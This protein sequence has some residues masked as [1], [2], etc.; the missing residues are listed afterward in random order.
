M[1]RNIV[2]RPIF[3]ILSLI[4]I[5][6]RFLVRSLSLS[7][8]FFFFPFSPFLLFSFF[9]SSFHLFISNPKI[10]SGAE[11][12]VEDRKNSKVLG[13]V[14]LDYQTI[15]SASASN[16]S[17]WYDITTSKGLPGSLSFFY[18]YLLI[19][20]ICFVFFIKIH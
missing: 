9:P 13:K 8:S 18:L 16:R 15:L 7:L 12:L 1:L 6:R 4:K 19:F 10:K 11:V 20:L 5:G 14:D 3:F 17:A 2:I